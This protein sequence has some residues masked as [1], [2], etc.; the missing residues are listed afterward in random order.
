MKRFAISPGLCITLIALIISILMI[1]FTAHAFMKASRGNLCD[2]QVYYVAAKALCE[3]QDPY[4]YAE[5]PYIYPPLFATLCMPLASFSANTAAMLYIPFMVAAVLLSFYLGIREY[6]RRFE[7]PATSLLVSVSL[8]I[9]FMIMEDRVKA[10]LQMFQVNSLLLCLFILALRWLDQRPRLAGI[11]L[12]LAMNIKAFPLI[13]LPYLIF[14]KR[15]Q[16]A[17]YMVGATVC[18]GLLPAVVLGWGKNLQYLAQSSGGFLS[19][20]GIQ[21]GV[22]QK[23]LIKDVTASYSVSISSGLVRMLGPGHEALAWTVVAVILLAVISFA[24]W[25]YRKGGLARLHWP[26]RFKQQEQPWQALIAL[27]WAVLLAV[28]LSV[29]PQTNSRHFLMLAPLAMLGSVMLVKTFRKTGWLCILV[30]TALLWASLTLPPG[31]F[32][33]SFLRTAHVFWQFVGGPS[34]ILLESLP[35]LI[36]G[37][38]LVLGGKKRGDE[39]KG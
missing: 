23:A 29:S 6:M 36:L 32:R 5:R 1:A 39:A 15:Y 13:M 38:V 28:A 7:V 33:I 22:Q 20:L 8:L 24:A 16:T 3:H 27:E 26:D 11:A 2:F 30:G 18:F 37:G 34:W 17:A 4:V 31:S 19:L 25:A 35:F 21:T 10:D 14:R 9:A 12:G